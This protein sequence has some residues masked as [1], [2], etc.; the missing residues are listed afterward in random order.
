MPGTQQAVVAIANDDT[1]VIIGEPDGEIAVWNPSTGVTLPL[2]RHG[3]AVTDIAVTPDGAMG[4][5][6]PVV[7]GSGNHSRPYAS[8]EIFWCPVRGVQRLS[9]L[10]TIVR[11]VSARA[12]AHLQTLTGCNQ[13]E[14]VPQSTRLLSDVGMDHERRHSTLAS[15]FHEQPCSTHLRAR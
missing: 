3:Q 2:G 14:V 7:R 9:T 13:S 1:R 6:P 8:A 15:C 10:L 4:G 11:P 12:A 5:V